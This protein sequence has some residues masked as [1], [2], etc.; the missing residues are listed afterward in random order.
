MSRF[1]QELKVIPGTARFIAALVYIALTMSY[2]TVRGC[3]RTIRVSPT[4]RKW[5]SF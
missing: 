1:K 2:R 5:A 4:R 3:S